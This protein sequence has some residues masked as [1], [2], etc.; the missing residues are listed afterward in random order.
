MLDAGAGHLATP[1]GRV[2][3]RDPVVGEPVGEDPRVVEAEYIDVG[4]MD[5]VV[6]Q[7]GDIAG[8]EPRSDHADVRGV[9]PHQFIDE[10]VKMQ[11]VLIK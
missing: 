6:G 11:Q 7:D 2:D 3:A 4:A 8:A 9:V 1:L 10:P 5:E